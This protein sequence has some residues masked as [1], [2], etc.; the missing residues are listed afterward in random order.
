MTPLNDEATVKC[1]VCGTPYKVS[2]TK[3]EDQSAC[4]SCEERARSNGM[5]NDGKWA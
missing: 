3:N 1:P 5:H 2:A 4:P